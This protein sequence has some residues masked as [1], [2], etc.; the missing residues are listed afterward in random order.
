MRP[1]V[2]AALLAAALLAS[3]VARAQDAPSQT[4]R[5]EDSNLCWGQASARVDA[6]LGAE[7]ADNVRL[8]HNN[9]QSD[10]AFRPGAM[11][12]CVVP[13]T[14]RNSFDLS[15]SLG[16]IRY[17]RTRGL[18]SFYVNPDSVAA[19][20]LYVGDFVVNIHDKFSIT[21]SGSQ[22]PD[23]NSRTGY[24]RLQ[25]TSGLGVDWNLAGMVVHAGYDHDW[26]AATRS[27]Y[28]DVNHNSDQFN[29]RI[30]YDATPSIKAGF[31]TGGGVTKY[32]LDALPDS[33]NSSAGLFADVTASDNISVRAGAGYTVYSFSSAPAVQY[34]S[35]SRPYARVQVEHQ[36]S[37]FLSQSLF[38]QHA[39]ALGEWFAASE[40]TSVAYSVNWRLNDRLN[41]EPGVSF[42]CGDLYRDTKESANWVSPQ[43]QLGW[44]MGPQLRAA[45]EY[46]YSA[47]QS[48][49]TQNRIAFNLDYRF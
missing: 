43:M 5:L 9:P 17:A 39:L 3:C 6:L 47:Y 25:N 14:E 42:H 22:T 23:I 12:R 11:F 37:R 24:G 30:A 19:F 40:L 4:T 36:I 27:G 34:S 48:H 38:C 49:Y 8:V 13:V 26:M 46:Q 41:F 20:S 29:A 15:T 16:Y 35:L 21:D 10:F 2:R 18:D 1:T 45:F 33:V 32:D 7:W 31:E 44:R 28:D